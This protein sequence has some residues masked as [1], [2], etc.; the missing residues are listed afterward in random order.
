[1]T[2]NMID[3]VLLVRSAELRQTRE[4]KPFLRM[5][6]G[7]RSSTLPAVLWDADESA[8]A[9]VEHCVA[10]HVAGEGGEP[11]SA[12]RQLNVAR[13]RRA[14]DHE[15]DWHELVDD[16]QRPAPGLEHDLDTLIASV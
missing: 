7:N 5:T 2:E 13:V 3:G 16:P 9:A 15:V 11:P 6:L 4:G 1:M 10:I 8:I 14:D 12:E